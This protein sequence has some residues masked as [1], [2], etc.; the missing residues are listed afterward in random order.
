MACIPSDEAE[1][2]VT[3]I[4]DD[5]GTLTPDG[6]PGYF[7]EFAVVDKNLWNEK[8]M[9]DVKLKKSRAILDRKTAESVQEV[10]RLM[11]R[12][13]RYPDK[14]R[15]GLDGETYHFSRAVPLLDGGRP[16]RLA[17]GF[18]QG[19]IWSPDEGSPADE[20]TAIGEQLKEFSL[21][22]TEGRDKLRTEILAKSDR[23]RA[24][25]ER[26]QLSK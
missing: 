16:P 17:G 8:S 5:E 2:I 21:A 13:V 26:P 6:K 18:E 20:L 15:N 19:Q 24:K 14:D 22:P 7:V 3:V 12:T 1:W 10:W 9:K 11:L 25:L 4:R 23:L